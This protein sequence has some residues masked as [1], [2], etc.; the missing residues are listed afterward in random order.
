MLR[1][2]YR[3][4]LPANLFALY[5]DNI[6]LGD[7]DMSNCL[8]DGD[9]FSSKWCAIDDF[10]NTRLLSNVKKR[11]D[12]GDISVPILGVFKHQLLLKHQF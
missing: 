6:D 12:S 7:R 2:D 1:E 5:L 4:H 3:P 9:V 11:A 8:C 10:E